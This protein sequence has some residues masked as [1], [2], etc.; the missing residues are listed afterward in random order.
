MKILVAVDSFKGTLRSKEIASLIETHLDPGK[1]TFDII[2]I[3]DG[4]EGTVES[5]QFATKGTKK[6]IQVR[7]PFKQSIPSYYVLTQDGKTAFIEVALSSGIGMIEHQELNPYTTSSYGLGETIKHTLDDKVHK[8]IVGIGGSSTND[9]GAGMLQA[10][11]AK[12]YDIDD[13]EIALMTGLSIGEVAR[14]DLSNLDRRLR[15]VHIEVA[16][17]VTNP[18]LGEQ[19]CAEIFS[20]QKGANED[21]V[22]VLERNMTHFADVVFQTIGRDFR[23]YPGS[24]A[25]GGLGFGFVAFLNAYLTSGLD[26]IADATNLK[27]RIKEADLVITG[28][29]KLDSQSL[30]GKAPIKVARI[31]KDNQKKVIGIFGM[32]CLKSTPEYFDE[33]YT[34]VPTITSLDESLKNPK[35]SIIS[36]IQTIKTE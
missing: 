11:G 20:R 26:I 12:F 8:I 10:L 27:D 23:N 28:E 13:N 35:E 1:H 14:I 19:G 7:G 5:L 29:G 22:L 3:A 31:A 9:G 15:Q 18:L 36:L 25:A 21:M 16:C 2:P 30:N 6:E 4:G 32:S 33:V 24:G 17:D 34:I